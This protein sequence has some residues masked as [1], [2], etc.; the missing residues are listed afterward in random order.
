M[1][2]QNQRISEYLLE[3]RIG[4]GSFGEVWLARHHAWADQLVAIKIPTD[5]AY[6]RNLQGEGNS[7]HGLDHPNIVE[8][9]GFDPFSDPPYLVMEFVPG[10][11]LRPLIQKKSLTPD[12]VIAVMKQILSGLAH[13][14]AKGVLH[15]DIKPENILVHERTGK[16][17]FD[18]AGLV[19]I[20][21]FGLGRAAATSLRTG[22]IQ[23]SQEAQGE[24]AR[25]IVGT[26]DYMA[27]EQRAGHTVDHRADLYACG[28]ILFEMLTGEKPAGTELPSD[29][30][31][32]SPK[33]LD[34]VFR[35]AFSRLEKRFASAEDFL[36]ALTLAPPPLPKGKAPP[37][38][39]PVRPTP[40]GPPPMRTQQSGKRSCPSCRAV[41][42]NEDQFCMYCGRQLV[43]WV[44]RCP[45]CSA[46][47]A[48]EDKFCQKCGAVVR[49]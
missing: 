19:K 4:G 24:E 13:A 35:R 25:K 40:S 6:I 46:Y 41:V 38:P 37:G 1:P 7:L 8:A 42:D 29:I 47:P 17:G 44:L 21:D 33:H 15:M 48:P 10:T 9:K 31:P 3:N 18:A 5:A 23:F 28:V 20:T 12:Q 11:S 36:K 39:P 32:R 2:K 16:E 43:D 26:L 45:Q 22:S 30:N 14:H 34:E 27:P 49:K